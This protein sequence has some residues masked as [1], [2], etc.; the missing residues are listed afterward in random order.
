MRMEIRTLWLHRDTCINSFFFYF[1]N[2][3]LIGIPVTYAN[4]L[5][6]Y[7]YP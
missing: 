3:A 1:I 5:C 7:I 2:F 4:T 6:N